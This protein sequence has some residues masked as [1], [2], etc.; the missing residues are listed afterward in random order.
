MEAFELSIDGNAPELRNSEVNST[1]EFRGQRPGAAMGAG[2]FRLPPSMFGM[3]NIDGGLRAV[4]RQQRSG[5]AKRR[6]EL[7]AGIPRAKSLC[8][9]E[10][11]IDWRQTLLTVTALQ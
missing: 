10:G 3:P 2:S 4:D 5:A 9:Y 1:L 11:R 7:D 8:G 6:G